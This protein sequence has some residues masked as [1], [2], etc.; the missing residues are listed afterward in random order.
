MPRI[1]FGL[2]TAVAAA[3]A[4][5]GGPVWVGIG[6]DASAVYLFASSSTDGVFTR[7]TTTSNCETAWSSGTWTVTS[8]SAKP[9]CTYTFA[10]VYGFSSDSGSYT[11]SSAEDPNNGDS[12]SSS[13]SVYAVSHVRCAVL[14]SGR[15]PLQTG[16][17]D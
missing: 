8:P 14:P 15:R 12:F 1:A 13:L 16:V 11:Y 5:I 3:A 9:E 2:V 10:M 17:L 4:L 7:S 6:C